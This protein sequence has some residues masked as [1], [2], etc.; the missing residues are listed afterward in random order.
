M[1]GQE[2]NA[3]TTIPRM[4]Y[5]AQLPPAKALR[6]PAKPPPPP[7][8]TNA[9]P[10]SHPTNTMVC[11]EAFPR[12][13]VSSPKMWHPP[14]SQDA[15]EPT[16]APV[17]S[18]MILDPDITSEM[19]VDQAII[20]KLPTKLRLKGLKEPKVPPIKSRLAKHDSKH[21][22]VQESPPRNWYG[23]MGNDR[24]SPLADGGS[25]HVDTLHCPPPTFNQTEQLRL[26]LHPVEHHPLELY[27]ASE[28]DV[29][30]AIPPASEP[31]VSS[32]LH[33]MQRAPNLPV[34]MYSGERKRRPDEEMQLSELY[35]KFQIAEGAS[36]E[37]D[38]DI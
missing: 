5:Q 16:S 25:V 38:D 3:E 32:G 22:K 6:S 19:I 9:P 21:T 23:T 30:L 1:D 33:Y 26:K 7:A 28:L 36:W 15:G 20:K 4:E 17:T 10:T 31:N 8:L 37:S 27:P 11:Q 2:H 29:A 35:S 34:Y 14:L 13:N 18:E 12:N 24:Q